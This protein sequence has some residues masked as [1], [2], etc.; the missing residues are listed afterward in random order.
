MLLPVRSKG[1]RGWFFA[2]IPAEAIQGFDCLPV[3]T[4]GS[5]TA[6][7]AHHHR[8]PPLRNHKSRVPIPPSFRRRPESRVLFFDEGQPRGVVPAAR[9]PHMGD[10]PRRG[11]SGTACAASMENG[12]G[13]IYGNA[14]AFHLRNHETRVHRRRGNPRSSFRRR[15]ESGVLIHGGTR[16]AI[17]PRIG[18]PRGGAPAEP[19]PPRP[20]PSPRGLSV[21]LLTRP[22]PHPHNLPPFDR[23]RERMNSSSE[24]NARGDLISCSPE[25]LSAP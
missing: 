21:F 18:R 11:G 25:S 1:R 8:Q 19:C 4:G 7:T 10:H 5:R 16:A 12:A 6:P 14:L 20:P 17:D 9:Y 3:K 23:E 13:R 15:P 2:V 24:R 22:A